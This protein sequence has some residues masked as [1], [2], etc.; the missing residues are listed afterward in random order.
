MPAQSVFC[1]HCGSLQAVE[2]SAG[3]FT[4]HCNSCLGTTIGLGR[5]WSGLEDSVTQ[6]LPLPPV[7]SYQE[8]EFTCS[9]CEAFLTVEM[10]LRAEQN[11]CARCAN[12]DEVMHISMEPERL[13]SSLSEAEMAF[14]SPQ[15]SS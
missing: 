2:S 11:P 15:D 12:L 9:H 7:F 13:A 10:V 14:L 8:N 1:S 6:Q 5:D 3:T 4:L